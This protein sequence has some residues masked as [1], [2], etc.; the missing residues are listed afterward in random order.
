M[1]GF[2]AVL[3]GFYGWWIWLVLVVV[4][5][6]DSVHMSATGRIKC[7]QYWLINL[8]NEIYLLFICENL[9]CIFGFLCN[10]VGVGV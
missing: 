6:T 1:E 8:L 9:M 7:M 5:F 2:L 10:L 3:S 4:V